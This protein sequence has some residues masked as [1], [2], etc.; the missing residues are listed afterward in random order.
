MTR[1]RSG[2]LQLSTAKEAL[3]QAGLWLAD[4]RS[5]GITNQRETTIV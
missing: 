5:V 1:A 2:A 4:I 3:A